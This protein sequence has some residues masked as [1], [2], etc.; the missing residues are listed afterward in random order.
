[1]RSRSAR[2]CGLAFFVAALLGAALSQCSEEPTRDLPGSLHLDLSTSQLPPDAPAAFDSVEIEVL[3]SGR[4]KERQVVVPDTA[5]A[6]QALFS[7]P[8]DE[9]YTLRIHAFGVSASP[10]PNESCD[11]GVLAVGTCPGVAVPAGRLAHARVELESAYAEILGVDGSPG[12]PEIRSWWRKVPGATGYAL[13]WYAFPNGPVTEGIAVADTHVVQPWQAPAGTDSV[14]F[15]V[16]PRFGSRRGVAGPEI[17]RDL[18]IWLDLPKIVSLDPAPGAAVEADETRL[19]IA[20]DRPIEESTLDAGLEWSLSGDGDRVPATREAFDGGRRFRWTP[21]EPLSMGA[22]YRV[23]VG[24]GIHDL[25]GRPFDGNAALPGLQDSLVYWSTLPYAPL[26]VVSMSPASQS[27][28]IGREQTITLSFNRPVDPASVDSTSLI[29]TDS[30]GGRLAGDIAWQYE[31]AALQWSPSAPYWFATVC[32]LRATSRIT[33]ARGRRLDQVAS[34]YPARE[35]YL[36]WFTTLDQPPGPRVASVSPLD[37]SAGVLQ[38]AVVRVEFESPVVAA[39]VGPTTFR[40]LR[41]GTIGIPGTITPEPGA[42]VFS[43]APTSPLSLGQMYEVSIRGEVGSGTPGI[44]DAEG[45]RLDQD[46]SSPG[47]QPFRSTFRVEL[48]L[49]VDAL[50]FTPA[51]PDTF[52]SRRASANLLFHREVDPASLNASTVQI[53]GPQG[54]IGLSVS[55]D[56]DQRQARVTPAS[57]LEPLTRYHLVVDSLVSATDGSLLDAD[58]AVPGRQAYVRSFTSEPDSIHPRVGQVTPAHQTQGVS[59]SDSIVVAFSSAVDPS[60]VDGGT[61]ELLRDGLEPVEGSV[62]ATSLSAVFLPSIPL[63]ANAAYR[64]RVTTGVM[65]PFHLHALDQDPVASGLQPFESVF[66]TGEETIAPRVM[67]CEPSS[68]ATG[69]PRTTAVVLMFSEPV[70]PSSVEEAFSLAGPGGPVSGTG[71][72]DASEQVWTFV[73]GEPLAWNAAYTI[74]L[75]TSVV[76]AAGNP[77]DQNPAAPGLQ[78]FSSGFITEA[79]EEPPRALSSEPSADE[80]EVPVDAIVRVHLSEPIARASLS[81]AALR[82]RSVAAGKSGQSRKAAADGDV[83]GRLVLEAEGL[84][85]SWQA[86]RLPDSLAIPLADGTRYQVTLDTLVTDLQGNRLDQDQA[87]PGRQPFVFSFETAAERIAPRVTALLPGLADVPVEADLR[88]VFSEAMDQASVQLPGAVRFT[89]LDGPDVPFSLDWNATGD[90]LVVD[91][92]SDLEFDRAYRIEVHPLATDQAGNSLDQDAGTPGAQAYA[93]QIHT[94]I[95]ETPPTVVSVDP[96]H[97]AVHVPLEAV[98][99]IVMS[100]PVDRSTVDRNSVFLEAGGRVPLAGEGE[101]LV[102]E[103]ATRIT[104]IPARPLAEASGYAVQVTGAVKDAAGNGVRPAFT[105]T[106]LTGRAPVIVWPAGGVC[107]AGEETH[108]VFGAASSYDPDG[109][110]AIAWAVWDWG[111]GARDSLSAPAGLVAGHTYACRDTAGCDGI[112]N[113]GDGPA[114]ETGPNGCDESYRV[115]L[116]LWDTHGYSSAD[117]LGVSF[118][119]F[120][121]RSFS[122]QPGDSMAPGDTV[123]IRFSRPVNPATLTGALAFQRMADTT[124]VACHAHWREG[125]RTLLLVPDAPLAGG[126]YRVTITSDLLDDTDTPLDQELCA[127]G[128]QPL[129]IDLAVRPSMRASRKMG[130]SRAR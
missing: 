114:D 51:G 59:V 80:T 29:V 62:R 4:I 44:V 1:M 41:D 35:D 38:S 40:V 96:P 107:P 86:V 82:V 54:A 26:Q 13:A 21:A 37:G 119:A 31:G 110:D 109:D 61:F 36:G 60:T 34:T 90:T 100:E 57:Q 5:G 98:I 105:A 83:P 11:Q 6:F 108:V 15:R 103:T 52:V 78:A 16:R 27:T 126:E 79:D 69:V 95:D 85:L 46:L 111:D 129:V 116:R 9:T 42:R 118:C 104:L 55:L 115:S 77:L 12:M 75:G 66:D 64:V 130:A 17:W 53:R 122:P 58:P 101:P 23:R 18:S 67:Q 72:L 106:F 73:P 65:D 33:D 32:T 68:G 20:F 120:L 127:P 19:E 63:D 76:D 45:D 97:Q 28:G 22:L 102:D 24:T 84:T 112:D 91:P 8:S 99:Q 93:A 89:L 48:P 39:S 10:W 49:T 47:Y 50:S 87:L 128:R 81:A 125:W 70:V 56:Q 3:L 2:R 113:D 94:E 124:D 74:S 88:V 25:L 117:T 121:A 71:S 14:C 92:A 30:W 123:G 7:L 43:F